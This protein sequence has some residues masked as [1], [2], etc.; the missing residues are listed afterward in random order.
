MQAFARHRY[1]KSL[2]PVEWRGR[3]AVLAKTPAEF[4]SALPALFLDIALEGIILWDVNDYMAGRLA[5]LRRLL[6]QRGMHRERR[7]G[8]FVW[9]WQEFPGYEWR[10]A[11]KDTQ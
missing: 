4:E 3:L 8:S 6:S 5:G 7:N 2:L 9:Q 1:V 10:L 11:W